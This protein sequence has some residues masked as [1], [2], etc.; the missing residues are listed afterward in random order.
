[1]TAGAQTQ[2]QPSL[3]IHVAGLS[4]QEVSL[5]Q[6]RYTLGRDATNAI[7]LPQPAS[8]H[9]AKLEQQ[10]GVWR[11]TDLQSRNGTF[12]KG[13]RVQDVE[14]KDGD[15]LHIGDAEGNLI[16]LIFRSPVIAPDNTITIPAL[17]TPHTVLASK[18]SLLPQ[19]SLSI[20]RNPQS[21]IPLASPMVSWQH[22]RLDTTSSGNILIDLGSTNG[23]FINGQ[24]ITGTYTLRKDDIIQIG[25]FRLVFD[26]QTIQQYDQRGGLRIDVRNMTLEVKGGRKILNNIS[27]S[28]EPR[29][30]IALVGGSGAGK[31]TLMKAISGFSR[32]T[33]GQKSPVLVNGEDYYRNFDAYRAV[34]GY[35][36]QD[37]ILHREL[38]VHTALQYSANL[39]L[40]SD[41]SPDEITNR[42]E[43]SLDDVEMED[44]INTQVLN[45]SG[46]QRKR[47]SIASELLAEPSLFFLDEPT[48][49][50]DPG[51]EKKMM[52]TLRRLADN[53]RT[54]VL[55]THA[56][57]NIKQCDHV[58]FMSQGHVLYFGPPGE[59]L[60]FFGVKTDSFSDIYTR[61]DA[62]PGEAIY[63]QLIE[64]VLANALATW[65]QHNHTSNEMPP[66]YELWQIKYQQ[67]DQYR[68][69]VQERQ[70]KSS[71]AQP[72]EE[73]STKQK[74]PRISWLRLFSILTR[75]Y[76]DLMARDRA[77]LFILLLQSPII[78]F[79]LLLLARSEALIGINDIKEV[80]P[81]IEAQNL[82][83]VLA[84]VAVWFGIINS[85]R[86]ITK[87]R[88][89][90]RRERMS[91]LRIWPYL[92]SKLVVLLLLAFIQNMLLLAIMGIKI[93]FPLSANAL[94]APPWLELFTTMM[95]VALAGT[96]IGLLI[97][98]FSKTSDQAISIVPL[99]LIPQILF[100]GL[101]FEIPQP[102]GLFDKERVVEVLSWPMVSRW[103]LDALGTSSNLNALCQL[104][105]VEVGKTGEKAVI[106]QCEV[107]EKDSPATDMER[108]VARGQG[109][110]V[111]PS[112]AFPQAFWRCEDP[113][114]DNEIL[115]KEQ[116][117]EPS[118]LLF[119]WGVLLLF[120]ILS[121]SLAALQLK[122]QDRQQ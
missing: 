4:S 117:H 82:L 13:Q 58:V 107:K 63:T 65:K 23:T 2:T 64:S 8:R 15:I 22:A 77:N 71:I 109:F 17:A 53:G 47:V 28:I 67:S 99:V 42:I 97:S 88:A 105:N 79:L 95:L 114:E 111:K 74:P 108:Q 45:L 44:H 60:A 101:I 18:T 90:Y 49:G 96:S 30:F 62:K 91:N 116:C 9:H 37:D 38:P 83:F 81:R 100:A 78:A 89:I 24:R 51:L 68:M 69:Y 54:I 57:E 14:L 35:V 34:L 52:Y 50:L 56:T 48:S 25:P 26:G 73:T 120:T 61:L 32:A 121:L 103:G 115:L 106:S 11:Y 80:I 70:Q 118:H 20:G 113:D 112:D 59:A 16:R 85:A 98:T 33:D 41:T 5:G 6:S 36:P 93:R 110:K 12:I 27:L 76:F 72:A 86:E 94:L 7:I 66:L 39:R 55:V 3:A 19:T 75:R 102:E 84:A 87:E 122:L 21:D 29:E 43:Q 10:G 31:S 119:T 40:P 46:G 92:F 104:P 1:M